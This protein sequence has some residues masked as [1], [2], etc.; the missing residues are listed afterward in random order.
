MELHTFSSLRKDFLPEYQDSMLLADRAVVYFNPHTSAH[1]K[2]EPITSEMV[3]YGFGQQNLE[4]YTDSDLLFNMLK[5]L[6]WKDKNLLLMSSGTFS[7]KDLT[8]L[9][10]DLI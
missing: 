3:K 8:S 6:N 4:V 9:A 5:Q 7:G 2:L 1:K 10:R